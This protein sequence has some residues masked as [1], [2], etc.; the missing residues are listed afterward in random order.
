MKQGIAGA[1]S[2]V[3]L[4]FVFGLEWWISFP[5]AMLVSLGVYFL[6]VARKG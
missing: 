6:L 4:R 2:Y 3:V 1:V 5:L